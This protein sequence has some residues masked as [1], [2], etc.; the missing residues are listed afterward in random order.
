MELCPVEYRFDT[1]IE[2]IENVIAAR[3][4]DKK[5]EFEVLMS[6]DIPGLSLW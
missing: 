3:I 6:K 5:L 1:F 4:F 2:G